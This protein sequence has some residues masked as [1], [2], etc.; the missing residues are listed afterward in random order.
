[1]LKRI[2]NKLTSNQHLDKKSFWFIRHGES[3][4]NL[5][6]ANCLVTHNAQLTELG[7]SEAQAVAEY[8]KIQN[9]AATTVYTSPLDRT[10]NTAKEI[11]N[12]L[13]IP[14]KAKIGLK[15][16]D[17]GTWGNLPWED[18]SEKLSGLSFNERYTFTPEGGESW[19]QMEERLIATLE[20][21]VEESQ[22]EE[23][24]LIVTHRGCLRALLPVLIG[25]DRQNHADFSVKTGSLTKLSFIKDD[26]DFIGLNP[27]KQ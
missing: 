12:A 6:E 8:F 24:L 14:V 27:I 5:P 10:Y 9:I 11:S 16:R 4:G 23:N 17:W 15:E 13:G 18:V 7:R 20:E 26:Y 2:K 19:K 21:I 1:M 22:S 3:E 25:A